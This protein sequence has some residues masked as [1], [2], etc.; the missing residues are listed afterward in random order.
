MTAIMMF[1]GFENVVAELFFLGFAIRT[2]ASILLQMILD[3]LGL[4]FTDSQCGLQIFN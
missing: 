3:S 4:F 2:S 1:C